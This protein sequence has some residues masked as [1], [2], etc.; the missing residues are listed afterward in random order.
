[1]SARPRGMTEK[2]FMVLYLLVGRWAHSAER[3]LRR[4]WPPTLILQNWATQEQTLTLLTLNKTSIRLHFVEL[5]LETLIQFCLSSMPLCGSLRQMRKQ[6]Y[7]ERGG[8]RGDNRG[9]RDLMHLEFRAFSSP[10]RWKREEI[11]KKWSKCTGRWAAGAAGGRLHAACV[12]HDW[13]RHQSPPERLPMKQLSQIRLRPDTV[14]FYYFFFPKKLFLFQMWWQ[15]TDMMMN[16]P[17]DLSE[18][19]SKVFHFFQDKMQH[20]VPNTAAP[21]LSPMRRSLCVGDVNPCLEMKRTA[22]LWLREAIRKQFGYNWHGF[23]K[24]I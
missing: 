3:V 7:A 2:W 4:A 14:C 1:M 20:L 24:Y 18:E 9:R 17:Q 22:S 16:T 15:R 23:W 21:L 19:F 12:S 13:Y 10:T 6:N 8:G 11:I 5:A